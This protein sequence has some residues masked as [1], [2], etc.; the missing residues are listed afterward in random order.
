MLALLYTLLILPIE[1]VI[2]VFL[3]A[4][5]SLS[6]NYGI[7]IVLTSVAINTVLIPIY[8]Q[9]NKWKEADHLMQQRMQPEIDKIKKSYSGQERHYYIQ[10]IHRRHRYSPLS[11]I[12]A[13]TGF[14]LQIPFFFAA[15]HLLSQYPALEGQS[16][17]FLNNLAAPDG[18]LNGINLMPFLMT[19]ISLASAAIYAKGM[20]AKEHYQ[21]WGLALLFL[22]LLYNESAG[23]LLY[24]TMNNVF[25]FCKNLVEKTAPVANRVQRLHRATQPLQ[26]RLAHQPHNTPVYLALIALLTVVLFANPVS[27]FNATTDFSLDLK[28]YLAHNYQLSL[29]IIMGFYVVYQLSPQKLKTTIATLLV[30]TLI[31]AMSYS[32]LIPS[33]YGDMDLFTFSDNSVLKT[34]RW[35]RARNAFF[36]LGALYAGYYAFK[37]HPNVI[38]AISVIGMASSLIF[39]A[40]SRNP[41]LELQAESSPIAA[42]TYEEELANTLAFS[43]DKNIIVLFL[44]G[45]NASQVTLALKEDPAFLDNYEG[46]TWF[47]NTLSTGTTT[48][49]SYL[50]LAGGHQYTVEAINQRDI[51][52]IADETNK[53]YRVYP[54]AFSRA[55]WHITFADPQYGTQFPESVYLSQYDYA[56]HFLQQRE[57]YPDF[58]AELLKSIDN[59]EE[60]ILTSIAIFK[61][62]PPVLKRKVYNG[63]RWLSKTSGGVV[64]RHL[65]I[66]NKGQ[67][68]GLLNALA[69]ESLASHTQN[70]FKYLHFDF[71]HPGHAID[72]EG[73]LHGPS[74][75]TIESQQA[76]A[77]I[78]DF[79]NRLKT[80][81]IYDNSMIILVSD[82][83][84][85]YTP[86]DGFSPDFNE[87]IPVGFHKK[88]QPSVAHALLMV[89]DFN[90]RGAL[91]ISNTFMSNADVAGIV[92]AQLQEGCGIPD[93]NYLQT[94][95][96]D[97]TLTIS[98]VNRYNFQAKDKFI[99]EDMYQV[100]E[101]LFD[102]NNWKAVK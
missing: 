47:K 88:M 16:F 95:P 25:Y 57:W 13:S 68:W 5:Y 36:I 82:H 93:A 74:N 86:T 73:D 69:D 21:L 17:L 11:S 40:T 90:A 41:E 85:T 7:A 91:D 48:G 38:K 18:L 30:G 78:G 63:G 98:T 10:T 32:F 6:N 28:A 67:H 33:S 37:H 24:W 59:S 60:V 2:Q 79:L 15:F 53:A 94:A 58:Q 61:A 97:R 12:K 49:S 23:L 83:G 50:A 99:V 27:L 52:S 76:L 72:A 54:D 42:T 71:P 31:I 100:R 9:A 3:E 101:H 89:K 26:Q 81:G 102:H 39:I 44:D 8:Y 64:G 84:W 55:G 87:H 66:N 14:L 1:T 92:C 20:Q 35:Q 19:A 34:S 96:A 51:V 62:T 45:F 70:T 22:V 29:L 46:F 4:T 80:L 75:Y 43:Q 56:Q 65:H 77:K